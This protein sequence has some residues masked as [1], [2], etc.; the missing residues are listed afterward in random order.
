M[1]SLDRV[2]IEFRELTHGLSFHVNDR[3]QDKNHSADLPIA[4]HIKHRVFYTR[5][6]GITW[7]LNYFAS[8]TA[9]LA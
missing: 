2:V 5:I 9:K 3:D 1:L 4:K 8:N 6:L 7:K